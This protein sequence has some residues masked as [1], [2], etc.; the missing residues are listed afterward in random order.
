MNGSRG[1]TRHILGG[2]SGPEPTFPLWGG[3]V[4]LEAA[5]VLLHEGSL[6]EET[7]TNAVFQIAYFSS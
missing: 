6:L 2:C 4:V 1:H 7:K 5:T 3:T